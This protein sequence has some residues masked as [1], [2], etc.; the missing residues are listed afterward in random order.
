MTGLERLAFTTSRGFVGDPSESL[1]F[2]FL[3]ALTVDRFPR[4][5]ELEMTGAD[6]D[7]LCLPD[8]IRFGDR[9]ALD[10]MAAFSELVVSGWNTP[11][12][13]LSA[14]SLDPLHPADT[15]QIDQVHHARQALS[16]ALPHGCARFV[17]VSHAAQG[18]PA[19][20]RDWQHLMP[21]KCPGPFM[22]LGPTSRAPTLPPFIT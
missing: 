13:I 9:K 1:L 19:T 8:I 20:Y 17:V 16:R 4:L 10:G 6:R 18:D 21:L 11:S 22:A 15:C 2:P 5:R 14:P 12:R 7:L 3:R